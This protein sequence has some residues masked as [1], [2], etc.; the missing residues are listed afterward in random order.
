MQRVHHRHLSGA[1]RRRPGNR[2][3]RSRTSIAAWD[4]DKLIGQ[5]ET[6]GVTVADNLGGGRLQVRDGRGAS[7]TVGRFA[8]TELTLTGDGT[9]TLTVYRCDVTLIVCRP[10]SAQDTVTINQR[11][12]PQLLEATPAQVHPGPTTAPDTVLTFLHGESPLDGLATVAISW[13]LTGAPAG[14]RTGTATATVSGDRFEL[15]LN[16]TGLPDGNYAFSATFRATSTRTGALTG[17]LYLNQTVVQVDTTAPVAE[18]YTTPAAQPLFPY[19]DGYRDADWQIQT[20]E[21]AIHAI[22]VR[23][24]QGALVHS[25]TQG[26]LMISDFAWDGRDQAGKQLSGHFTVGFELADP[27]G[28]RTTMSIADVLIYPH[29]RV[30]QVKQI[31]VK[32]KST[33]DRWAGRCSSFATPSSHRWAG[34]LAL[35]SMTKCRQKAQRSSGLI[36]L[37]HAVVPTALDYQSIQLA[38]YGAAG[39][40]GPKSKARIQPWNSASAAYWTRSTMGRKAGSY[41]IKLPAISQ[42]LFD[43]RSIAWRATAA[44]G[45]RYDLRRFV[46]T[47]SYRT[48]IDPNDGSVWTGAPFPRLVA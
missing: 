36:A 3:A 17:S 8:T 40:S 6:F 4:T 37:Y 7:F 26:P 27:A 35:N 19:P 34:S 11:I 45:A 43:G 38:G 14:R 48:L 28:N 30:S 16:L 1:D 42:T 23:D 44:K 18:F 21:P 46:V 41:P 33:D 22:T 9:P 47:V 12:S 13:T 29:R 20:N 39:V 2:V 5:D 24:A 31:I 15:P 25:E 32:A 10:T